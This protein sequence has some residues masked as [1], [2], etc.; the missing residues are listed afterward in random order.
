MDELEQ[1][2]RFA[3][4]ITE[5][6]EKSNTPEAAEMMDKATQAFK[7]IAEVE[8]SR[9]E[10]RKLALEESKLRYDL[11]HGPQRD[12]SERTK[13]YISLLVPILTTAILAATLILQ[14]YQFTQSEKHKQEATEDAQWNDAIKTISASIKLAPSAAILSPFLKSERYGD[15]AR[16]KADDLMKGSDDPQLFAD[17]FRSVY[18]PLE[19]KNLPAVLGLDQTLKQSVYQLAPKQEHGDT[20]TGIEQSKLDYSLGAIK[21]IGAAIAPVLRNPRP[22]NATLSL[23]EA[24]FIDCD[25]RQ[26]SLVGANLDNAWFIRVNLEGADLGGITEFTGAHFDLTAWWDA[27]RIAPD[28]LEHLLKENPYNPL[29]AYYADRRASRE[30]YEAAVARLKR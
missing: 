20:L 16:A 19:W 8:Q 28:L 3:A 4:A 29:A 14:G 13:A 10:A 11:D 9:A 6:F 15:R 27:Y 23:R 18:Q 24:Y 22:N 5:K 17:L 7:A 12:R 1:L 30:Q 25:W 2:R 26:V 21:E